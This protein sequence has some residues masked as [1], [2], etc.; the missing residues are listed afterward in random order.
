MIIIIFRSLQITYNVSDVSV[1]TSDKN[2]CVSATET[3]GS[4][5]AV[6]LN[7]GQIA[8]QGTNQVSKGTQE[9]DKKSLGHRNF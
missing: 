3:I 8:P 1:H 6:A 7:V 5:L 9:N 4:S 2:E